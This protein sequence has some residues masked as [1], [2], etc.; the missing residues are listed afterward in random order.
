[1]GDEKSFKSFDTLLPD[2]EGFDFETAG[3]EG[4]IRRRFLDFYIW[5]IIKNN[6]FQAG[7]NIPVSGVN[8]A[9]NLKWKINQ[10]PIRLNLAAGQFD[11]GYGSSKVTNPAVVG[12]AAYDVNGE[13]LAITEDLPYSASNDVP[14][15]KQSSGNLAVALPGTGVYYVWLEYL[16]CNED[17]PVVG[18]DAVVVFPNMLDGYR[19]VITTDPVAP[20]GDGISL[21]MAKIT[22]AIG[23]GS[24]VLDP[25]LTSEDKVVDVPSGSTI[26]FAPVVAGD[27]KRAYAGV[28]DNVVQVFVDTTKKTAVYTDQL[29]ADLRAHV[30][31]IGSGPPTPRNPHGI[32]RADEADGTDEPIATQDQADSLAEGIVDKN[33]P[34][35]SPARLSAALQPV[36]MTTILAPSTLDA[37][38]TGAGITGSPKE[39]WIRVKD[40]NDSALTKAA[41]LD[42][43]RHRR[44][45]PSV[46]ETTT[47]SGDSSILP[48]DP[49]SG[50][51]WVGF[52]DTEDANGVYRILATS[53]VLV[54]TGQRVLLLN[55]VFLASDLTTPIPD[56]SPGQLVIGS[57]YWDGNE[58]TKNPVKPNLSDSIA[59]PLIVD[60][61]RSAGLVGPQ[62]LSTTLKSDPNK[63]ALSQQALHNQVANSNY[64]FGVLGVTETDFGPGQSINSGSAVTAGS[65]PTIAQPPV[66]AI[67]GREWAT[68]AGGLGTLGASYINH[69][70]ENLRPGRL[71]SL[72]FNYKASTDFNHR[73]RVGLSDG[74]TSA[75]NSLTT[76]DGI[77][78]NPPVDVTIF[79]DAAW[80]RV[81]ILFKTLDTV[82][83]DPAVAKYLEFLVQ[84]GGVV[85]TAGTIAVTNIQVTEGEWVPAY[86]NG[87]GR[88]GSLF[89]WDLNTS[90]PPGSVEVTDTRQRFVV[91]ADG[92]IITVGQVSAAQLNPGSPAITT[93][94]SD[95]N[96]LSGTEVLSA[97]TA[98]LSAG[99][100]RIVQSGKDTGRIVLNHDHTLD[101]NMPFYGALWCREL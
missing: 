63:G 39:R 85:S 93:G 94:V 9:P 90:C 66:G 29:L 49:E 27:P 23:A 1:M 68:L 75:Q 20:N 22:W 86:S 91:G 72:A 26:D 59:N 92:T 32:M 82:D 73:F 50:D 35:N 38:A 36:V 52:N 19:I 3:R 18:E 21:F 11:I 96:P 17:T 98:D 53:V 70:L 100:G 41:Y 24:L 40:L 97:A 54:S 46:R 79:N 83:P 61:Q 57:C 84:Q 2:V 67:T 65:D 77:S 74:N 15:G 47:N 88:P 33:I 69:V 4:E 87:K 101:G 81:S 16:E 60:D 58:V 7:V 28:R 14:W 44:L 45:Y 42:G 13:R 80:H 64:A 48:G 10:F 5:G 30:N 6:A 31:A 78:A 43:L 99:S 76:L 51:G 25:T 56:P 34:Q 62:Q 37:V 89:V 95:A 71:Y 55:K 12:G 8:Q